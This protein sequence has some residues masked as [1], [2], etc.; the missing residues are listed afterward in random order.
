V[1]L[2]SARLRERITIKRRTKTSNN[3]GA[4]TWGWSTLSE[5]LPAEVLFQSGKEAVLNAA[6]QGVTVYRIT[7]RFRSDLHT[8]DQILWRG[9]ELNIRSVAPDPMRNYLT[10][11]AD[12]ES[13][14]VS[15]TAPEEE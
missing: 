1:T 2:L 3:R 8:S 14:H 15:T 10:I 9:E 11:I 4:W 7:V 13:P 12:T 6:L 5:N